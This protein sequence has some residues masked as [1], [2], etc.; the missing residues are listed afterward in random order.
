MKQFKYISG[1][2]DADN[3]LCKYEERLKEALYQETIRT[4]NSNKNTE[5]TLME[6]IKV[7]ESMPGYKDSD[8]MREYCR[9]RIDNIKRSE[10]YNSAKKIMQAAKTDLN[11]GIKN[12]STI[13]IEE[14]IE[15]LSEAKKS[16]EQIESFEDAKIQV[17]QC[18]EKMKEYAQEKDKIYA[19]KE[20][21]EKSEKDK[22]TIK[23]IIILAPIIVLFGIIILYIAL[24]NH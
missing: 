22:K 1:Y 4:I 11:L 14:A 16:F 8:E 2:K 12:Q 20:E 13:I 19:Y 6:A 18:E 5:K 15:K 21:M 10:I 3:Y 24:G 9:Q 23:L 17:K 7:F